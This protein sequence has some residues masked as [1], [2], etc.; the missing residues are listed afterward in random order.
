MKSR[1]V[2]EFQKDILIKL[3]VNIDKDIADTHPPYICKGYASCIGNIKC[4][5]S[6]VTINKAIEK[7][8]LTRDI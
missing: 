3:H 6:K 8:R 5:G 4:N 1:A 7:E 2:K